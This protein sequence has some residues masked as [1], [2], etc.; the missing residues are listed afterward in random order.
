[1]ETSSIPISNIFEEKNNDYY[2]F[3]TFFLSYPTFKYYFKELNLTVST[4]NIIES[5]DNNAKTVF[6]NTI[7]GIEHPNE[8]P[9]NKDFLEY[10]IVYKQEYITPKF[11]GILENMEINRLNYY[12]YFSELLEE[13]MNIKV[14]ELPQE[15][16]QIVSFILFINREGL[17]YIFDYP[18]DVIS[19]KNRKLIWTIMKDFCKV[20][21]KIGLSCENDKRT[22][23]IYTI[24]KFNNN[25]YYGIM[26]GG[27]LQN[28]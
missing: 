4:F 13:Y 15:I 14:K 16:L 19:I 28:E 22:G 27:D 18:Y 26:N 1:M 8:L 2:N 6:F 11:D 9:T 10:D 12:N 25:D 17:I 23:C 20:N 21:H 5:N 7:T 24:K 3:P